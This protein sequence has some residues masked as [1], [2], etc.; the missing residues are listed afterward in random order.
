MTKINSSVLSSDMTTN[1]TRNDVSK[2]TMK[3]NEKFKNTIFSN[4]SN[5]KTLY[6]TL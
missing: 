4:I 6:Q 3:H 5:Q 1:K 2:T